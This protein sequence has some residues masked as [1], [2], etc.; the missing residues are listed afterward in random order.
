MAD[1][2]DLTFTLDE[3]IAEILTMLTGLTLSY[4]PEA[5]RYYTLTNTINRAM[6]AVALDADWSCYSSTEDVGTVHAGD[7][8]VELRPTV[9][10]R[11]LID[12]S[13]RLCTIDGYP[14]VW[15]HFLPRETIHK[16][17]NRAQLWVAHNKSSLE[18]SRPFHAGEEG[19]IIKVPVMR[20]PVMFRLPYRGEDPN[21]PVPEVPDD[22]RQQLVD[23]VWPDLVIAK[24]AYFYAQTQPMMQPRVQT[25]EANYNDLMYSLK[26]RDS[27]HTDAPFMNPYTVPVENDINGGW[28]S[29]HVPYGDMGR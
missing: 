13:V 23:H 11:I 18:F 20:E 3:A 7:R 24:A 26:D 22:V 25:L 27:K 12:D 1:N 15:A 9:R 5:D 21:V 6:R 29:S 14:M 17:P 16:V 10:P 8:I 19:L 2:P 4:E 28:L